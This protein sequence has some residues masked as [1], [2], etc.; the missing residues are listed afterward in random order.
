MKVIKSQWRNLS[1]H[2]RFKNQK[3]IQNFN[4]YE[5]FLTIGK[6]NT[7]LLQQFVE[8]NVLLINMDVQL[9]HLINKL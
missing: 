5:H 7:T 6:N 1:P 2:M 9:E 3:K 4:V 8:T